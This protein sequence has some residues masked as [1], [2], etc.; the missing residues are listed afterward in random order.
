MEIKSA[1][2]NTLRKLLQ[3]SANEDLK[4]TTCREP[5]YHTEEIIDAV[6][7]WLDIPYE[8][9]VFDV[10]KTGIL[11]RLKKALRI[12]NDTKQKYRFEDIKW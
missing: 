9:N 2:L 8:R 12:F 6:C 7:E 4:C 1:K 3:I 11:Y 10:H 5:L